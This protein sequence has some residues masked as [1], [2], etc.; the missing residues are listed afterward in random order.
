MRAREPDNGTVLGIDV[1]SCQ[2]FGQTLKE[3]SL[4]NQYVFR[5]QAC[6]LWELRPGLSRLFREEGL[7]P[8]DA[9]TL[10]KQHLECF[11][12]RVHNIIDLSTISREDL[13]LRGQHYGLQTPILDWTQC[14]FIAAFF[15]FKGQPPNTE[16]TCFEAFEEDPWCCVW[17]ARR[18][19]INRRCSDYE[20]STKAFQSMRFFDP[21]IP[22]QR[23]RDQRGLFSLGPTLDCVEHIV[24]ANFKGCET[25]VLIQIRIRR[26][27]TF[28]K[29]LENNYGLT[30]ATM[31]EAST[32]DNLKEAARYCNSQLKSALA[33]VA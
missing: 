30:D 32:I 28:V 20:D 23:I 1:E 15:A 8:Q 21:K 22:F 31:L 18:C 17:A 11:E 2:E 24:K 3:M 33:K 12:E 6:D 9:W 7:L 14:P 19:S 10:T 26:T 13:W 29:D 5:G 25:P 4:G 16:D 27:E